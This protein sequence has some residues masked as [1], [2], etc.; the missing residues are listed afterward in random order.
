MP[1]LLEDRDAIR[2]LM[3]RYNH[4][5]DGGE[6]DAWAALFTADGVLDSGTPLEGTDALADF[7]KSFAAGGMKARHIVLNEVI[8]V[9]GDKATC[10][11]Y[12]FLAA[13]TPPS[14]AVSGAYNDELVRVD[15][16]WKYVRRTFTPDS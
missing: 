2:D 9:D 1:T 4:Y 15:G 10:K 11:A 6:A 3:A 16:Q 5:F 14:L 12:F 7:A 13:G 8:E